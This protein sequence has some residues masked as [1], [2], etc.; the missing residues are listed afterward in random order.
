MSLRGCMVLRTIERNNLLAKHERL[1]IERNVLELRGNTG[2][3]LGR[4]ESRLPL[5]ILR[6]S[7]AMRRLGGR[8]GMLSISLCA[9]EM[10]ERKRSR[11]RNALQ[12]KKTQLILAIPSV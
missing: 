10:D 11:N 4:R 2:F 1:P 5:G 12:C 6:G 7:Q 9:K 3:F 8:S